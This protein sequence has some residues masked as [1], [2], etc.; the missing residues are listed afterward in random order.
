[1]DPVELVRVLQEARSLIA[2]PAQW[3]PSGYAADAVGRFVP[4]GSPRAQRFSTVGAIIHACRG[5]RDLFRAVRVVLD[6]DPTS[7]GL[8]PTMTHTESLELLDR[9][10]ASLGGRVEPAAKH[11]G[12]VRRS[13]GAGATPIADAR[14]RSGE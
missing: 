10:I 11:S 4:V 1:M 7:P 12:F 6:A 2:S 14:R 3:Q 8:D 5:A 9:A 13:P